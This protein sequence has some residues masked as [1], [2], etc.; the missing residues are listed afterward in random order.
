[1]IPIWLTY[2]L[3]EKGINFQHIS[4][5]SDAMNYFLHAA[6]TLRILRGLR[7]HK[8]I[9]LLEDEVNRFL[10]QMLLSIVTMI[11]FGS[12]ILFG[13]ILDIPDF[14]PVISPLTDAAL[15]QYLER[16]NQPYVF[17]VW[18]YYIVVTISTVGYGDISP[19]TTL[20]RFM[21]MFIIIF[22]IT[23]VPQQ[24][25]ELIEKM[26]RSSVWSRAS[27]NPR[28]KNKHVLICGD[29]KSTSL[30]EFFSELFHEDHESINLNAVILQPGIRALTLLPTPPPPPPHK[31]KFFF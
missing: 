20:G 3:F 8:K 28:G 15:M 10:C 7:L 4:T 6:Y 30:M 5:F 17:H 31:K 24:T 16:Q 1:V 9:L 25:N 13:F 18:V 19:S 23:F 12:N 2:F 22:S 14:S 27:Y 11:L 29:L 26:N 21:A